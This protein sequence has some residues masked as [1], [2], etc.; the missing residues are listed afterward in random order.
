[1]NVWS[2]K[3]EPPLQYQSMA[4]LLPATEWQAE[5]SRFVIRCVYT[6]GFPG[7]KFLTRSKEKIGIPLEEQGIFEEII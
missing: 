1:M 3:T 6:Y 2:I 7:F 4:A 5:L